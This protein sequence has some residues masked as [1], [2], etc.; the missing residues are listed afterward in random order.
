MGGVF[1][2]VGIISTTVLIGGSVGYLT[3]SEFWMGWCSGCLP[4]FFSSLI[5]LKKNGTH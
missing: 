2:W 3:G 5:D 4:W 1:K